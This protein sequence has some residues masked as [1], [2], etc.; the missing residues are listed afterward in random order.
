MR[1]SAHLAAALLLGAGLA[2]PVAAV[3]PS[4]L[5][6]SIDTLRAD[7]LGAFGYSR[8]TSPHIDRLLAESVSFVDAHTVEPLTAPSLVSVLTS[9]YPHDHAAT[10]NGLRMRDALPSLPKLLKRRGYRTAAFV[11]NWTLRNKLTGLE[12]HFEDYE[13]ILEKKR[14]FGLLKGEARAEDLN[15]RALAWLDGTLEEEGERPFFLWVHYVEPHAPYVLQEDAAR[16]LGLADHGLSDSDRYDTEIAAVDEGL[17]R[18]L[19]AVRERVRT[20]DLIVIFLSDHGESLGEH[21][22]TGH[23]RH[24]FE[25]TLHVP[26]SIG[27]PGH[28]EP[29]RIEAPASLLDLAPT[30]ASLLG[31]ERLAGFQGF[32]WGPVLD[33]DAE[34]PKDRVIRVQAHRGAVQGRDAPTHVR[35][36][37]LL[38]VGLLSGRRK[39]IFRLGGAKHWLFDLDDDPLELR[40]L[41]AEGSPVSAELAAWLDTVRK[42]LATSD[43]LPPNVLD[44]DDVEAL[45]ALGYLDD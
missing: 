7:R 10:R 32:D 17:G 21:G 4:V 43:E 37:G 15:E 33:G 18:L 22:Y 1:R 5:L 27:W 12:E 28:L 39:E 23:G 13:A 16:R 38:E 20:E 35:T 44:E 45:R 11:G 31:I 9:L 41:T 40:S 29:R 34:A 14:W 24:L 26:F 25:P 42:G 8:P 30:I 36:R 2:A 3:P 6:L 19:A